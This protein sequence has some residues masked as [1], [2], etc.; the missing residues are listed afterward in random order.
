MRAASPRPARA[1]PT[2]APTPRRA[3]EGEDAADSPQAGVLVGASAAARRS[4]APPAA[5][6]T[7][8][9]AKAG[10]SSTAVQY[11]AGMQYMAQYEA[12]ALAVLAGFSALPLERLHSIMRFTASEPRCVGLCCGRW[13]H[14][15]LSAWPVPGGA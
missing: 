1:A 4:P 12:K 3:A 8:A 10:V 11:P 9:G 2:G 15:G 7:A 6:G 13:L 14:D 5:T